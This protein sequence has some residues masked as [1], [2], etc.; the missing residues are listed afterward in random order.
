MKVVEAAQIN[1]YV[2]EDMG[3]SEWFTIDQG[4][5]NDFA[6]ATLDHQF[7]HVDPERAK[8]TPFGTTIA[9]GYLT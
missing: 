6:A 4:R 9:H 7:I 3:A 2:G 1:E 8:A 5:I